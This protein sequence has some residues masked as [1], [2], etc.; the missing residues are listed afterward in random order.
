MDLINYFFRT[1]LPLTIRIATAIHPLHLSSS[2]YNV[3]C[4]EVPTVHPQFQE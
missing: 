4:S 3:Q 2:Y 1:K